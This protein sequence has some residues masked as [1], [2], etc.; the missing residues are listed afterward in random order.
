MYMYYEIWSAE[1]NF[2]LACVWI[3]HALFPV[4]NDWNL[5]A[6]A[7]EI[8]SHRRLQFARFDSTCYL[9]PSEFDR[10]R[11]KM[12]LFC[13]GFRKRE[14]VYQLVE[15]NALIKGL[16][17]S[18]VYLTRFMR[19]DSYFNIQLWT[20]IK[21]LRGNSTCEYKFRARFKITTSPLRVFFF[22]VS[23]NY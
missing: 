23:L 4:L 9:I 6:K 1:V 5:I 7:Y 13:E 12:R 14:N 15:P 3:F 11:L 22:C 17:D 16:A 10:D 2:T 21:S 8:L 20:F 18:F 19:A